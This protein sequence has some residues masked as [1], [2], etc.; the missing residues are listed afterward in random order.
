MSKSE[1]L[2]A[3]ARKAFGPR[4]TGQSAGNFLPHNL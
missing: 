2:T 1:K 3:A 4:A